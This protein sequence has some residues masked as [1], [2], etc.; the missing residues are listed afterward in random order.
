M[1]QR[2]NTWVVQ[3]GDNLNRIAQLVYGYDNERMFA[4]ISRLN[5]GVSTIRSGMVLKLPMLKPNSQ[6]FIA[7]DAAQMMGMNS[8]QE[9]AAWYSQN[10]NAG[11]MT[12][13]L[14]PQR[15]GLAWLNS[16][17]KA[18]E[19]N[20]SLSFD[21]W[22]KT[23]G[24]LPPNQA[25][26]PP[27]PVPQQAS[28]FAQGV[29]GTMKMPIPSTAKPP[30][31]VSVPPGYSSMPKEAAAAYG[32]RYGAQLTRISGTS[33][34]AYFKK[35]EYTPPP[36]PTLGQMYPN[37][38]APHI[39]EMYYKPP[40]GYTYQQPGSLYPS[41]VSST[42]SPE[43]EYTMQ[44]RAQMEAARSAVTIPKSG[45]IKYGNTTLYKS[46]DKLY[47]RD[48]SGRMTFWGDVPKTGEQAKPDMSAAATTAQASSTN[49]A[50]SYELDGVGYAKI[51]PTYGLK[52]TGTIQE[53]WQMADFL[54]SAAENPSRLTPSQTDGINA[55]KEFNAGLKAGT[56]NYSP[57]L[58]NRIIVGLDIGYA[59]PAF[60]LLLGN[61]SVSSEAFTAGDTSFNPS[62]SYYAA[63][64]DLGGG[65][66]PFEMWGGGGGGGRRR[67]RKPGGGGNNNNDQAGYGGSGI[68]SGYTWRGF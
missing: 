38:T 8:E 40:E 46:G 49:A 5:G 52:P 34:S 60:N 20:P 4:E 68:N 48:A 9:V 50:P 18:R 42:L 32:A 17:A 31:P 39:S 62:R 53:E 55:L 35:N 58:L 43:M 10:P 13:A 12:R 25:K 26:T 3:A 19:M 1:P 63:I 36:P 33:P 47:A 41:N 27:A 65:Q 66:M 16:Y 30:S 37:M 57:S 29:P 14:D 45:P 67:G 51:V 15:Q 59:S 7:N 21:D 11:G 56:P 22:R 44:A 24:A 54:K 61:T 6:I 23:G 28:G 2:G 64:M